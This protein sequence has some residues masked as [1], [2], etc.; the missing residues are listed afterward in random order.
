MPKETK[1][2]DV[3]NM[4]ET[5]KIAEDVSATKEPRI[6]RRDGQDLAV[7]MPVRKRPTP[8]SRAKPVTKDDPVFGLIGIGRSEV[9]D[10]SE[11]KHKY[12]AE[13]HRKHR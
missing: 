4:P 11:N 8:P 7:I 3:T 6:L 9:G 5:L 1:T 13:A 10:I 2:I 12:L